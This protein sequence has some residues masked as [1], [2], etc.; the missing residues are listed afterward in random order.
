[1]DHQGRYQVR[2]AS[3]GRY[4]LVIISQKTMRGEGEHPQAS[5]LAQ[6][7]R[8]LRPPTQLLGQQAYRWKELLLRSDTQLDVVF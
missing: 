4:Y 8:Y 3:T 5:E 2:A 7:G 6:L 1:V